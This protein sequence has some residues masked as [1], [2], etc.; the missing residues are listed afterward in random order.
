MHGV[1]RISRRFLINLFIT[2]PLNLQPTRLLNKNFD[3]SKWHT[4]LSFNL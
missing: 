3:K 2:Y 4:L 1:R